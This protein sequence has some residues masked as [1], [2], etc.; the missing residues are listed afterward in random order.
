MELTAIIVPTLVNSIVELTGVGGILRC[1]IIYGTASAQKTR[2]IEVVKTKI[3][4]I[5]LDK[6]TFNPLI[7]L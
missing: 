5:L 1:K 4:I 6:A 3:S 2:K 7:S